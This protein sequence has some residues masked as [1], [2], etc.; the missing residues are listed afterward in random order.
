MFPSL[1]TDRYTVETGLLIHLQ[2]PEP[3]VQAVCAHIRTV[4]SMTYGD[5]DAVQ[6]QTAPGRQSFRALGHGRNAPTADIVHVPCV[7]VSFFITERELDATLRAIYH[8]HPYEEPVIYAQPTLR[9]LH[10]RGL[11][12]D[13]P[14]RFWNQSTPDWVPDEHR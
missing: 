14:N 2:V 12:E 1:P 13:N 6:F 9:S 3:A 11:D 10:I 7:E 4:T 8:A 5:Y